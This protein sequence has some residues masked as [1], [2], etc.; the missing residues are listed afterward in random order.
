M[1]TAYARVPAKPIGLLLAC[2]LILT[3]VLILPL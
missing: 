2:M 1:T 3:V